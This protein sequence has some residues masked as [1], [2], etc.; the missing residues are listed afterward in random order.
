MKTILVPTDFSMPAETAMNYAL[1]LARPLN[2]KVILYHA[3]Q[4]A[5]PVAEVPFA[6]LNDE[7]RILKEEAEQKLQ[8]LGR[9]I[10]HAGKISYEY[11]A[12]NGDTVSSILRAA[13]EIHPDMIVMGTTGASGL[14]SVIFGSVCLKVMEK[15][16]CPVM[17][18]PH[19]FAI[20]RPVKRITFATDYHCSDLA[21]ILK[22]TE[23][24]AATG[25]VINVLHISDAAIGGDEERQLM[26]DFM[27]KLK[28]KTSYQNLSFQIIHGYNI[29]DRLLKYVEDD[30]TDMLMMATH[31]RTFFDR[32]FTKSIT[33]EVA[34]NSAIPVVA[35]H[36]NA[37]TGVILF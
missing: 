36:F 21:D 5:V 17:A 19:N 11:I 27:Q 8:A 10:E 22:A 13:G 24:A 2:A 15:A 28:A 18:V 3:Y 33:K 31:Y 14:A 32:L 29:E 35:F 6:V 23:L 16:S 30:S 34:K 9:K 20:S 4:V 7:Q 26:N 25:A 37:K 1:T 12:E